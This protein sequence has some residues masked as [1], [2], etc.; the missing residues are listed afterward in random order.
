MFMQAYGKFYPYK[1]KYELH[2]VDSYNAIA[3][4]YQLGLNVIGR[5]YTKLNVMRKNKV[6]DHKTFEFRNWFAKISKLKYQEGFMSLDF[7]SNKDDDTMHI[8]K[9][10]KDKFLEE[11]KV[12]KNR[13]LFKLC[14]EKKTPKILK[15]K[16]THYIWE[17]EIKDQFEVGVEYLVIGF[18][19]G[20]YSPQIMI[21]NKSG[22]E[23]GFYLFDNVF[24]TFEIVETEDGELKDK[25]F[26]EE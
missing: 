9:T 23:S 25:F 20:T 13:E 7:S 1:K 26:K 12:G 3:H 4:E 15:V 8:W 22:E 14:L 16:T 11:E 6:P 2:I 18:K 17:E 19:R 21:E 5:D 10:M 24:K